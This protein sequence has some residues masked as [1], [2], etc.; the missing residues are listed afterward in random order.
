[1]GLV[2]ADSSL[3]ILILFIQFICSMD[4]NNYSSGSES[5]P[6]NVKGIN[7]YTRRAELLDQLQPQNPAHSSYVSELSDVE[8]DKRSV[9]SFDSVALHQ[10]AKRALGLPKCTSLDVLPDLATQQ[11]T[12]LAVSSTFRNSHDSLSHI[13]ATSAMPSASEKDYDAD[14]E[15]EGSGLAS[16][17][18]GLV[19]AARKIED[20]RERLNELALESN[21]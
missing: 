7:W 20:V 1:M 18:S 6:P 14:C 16:T 9:Q 10:L 5:E 12:G 21:S 2:K 17:L 13:L 8:G 15:S 19:Q 11:R 3:L 4:K